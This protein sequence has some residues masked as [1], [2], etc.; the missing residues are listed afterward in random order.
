M[1][2]ETEVMSQVKQFLNERG[3]PHSCDKHEVL[4]G[5]RNGDNVQFQWSIRIGGHG[6]EIVTFRA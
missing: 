6:G 4:R 2:K 1:L 5:W 3:Y